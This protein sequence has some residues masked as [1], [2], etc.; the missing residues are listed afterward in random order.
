MKDLLDKISSYN[1]FNYLFP[2][3][4]FVIALNNFT[5]YNLVQ[6][7]LLHGVFFYYFVGLIISRI[8]SLFVEPILK[9]FSLLKFAEYKKF[10]RASKEDDTL[11]ILS[12]ANNMYRTISTMFIVLIICN[13]Y[14]EL[15]E[16]IIFFSIYRTIII[17]ILLL[18]IFLFSYIKQ[19]NYIIKRINVNGD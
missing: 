19:S 13:L 12:E 10:V 9:Y 15:E 17:I 16:K 5:K 6:V 18:I 2:G 4:I 11:V 14:Q 7:D 3:I 1:L 8:G